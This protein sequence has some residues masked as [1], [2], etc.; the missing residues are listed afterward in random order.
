M[1]ALLEVFAW[2]CGVSALI[3]WGFIARD[4]WRQRRTLRDLADAQREKRPPACA[5]G[6]A[7]KEHCPHCLARL[8]ERSAP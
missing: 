4:V 8:R 1:S 5:H 6:I 7:M 3:L 2:S